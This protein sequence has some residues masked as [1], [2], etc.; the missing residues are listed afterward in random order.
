[1]ST[2][3]TMRNLLEA[4]IHFGHQTRRWHPKMARYIFGERNGI[5]IIDLKHTLRQLQK[6]YLAVRDTSAKGGT[7]LFVGTKKQAREAIQQAA[8]RSGMYYMNNR[9]L[10]GTLTNWETIQKSINKLIRLEEMETSGKAEAFSKKERVGMRKDRE[11]LEKNL[12]GIK[13][14]TTL[15]SIIFIIDAQREHIAV[16]EAKR[17]GIP[18]IAVVDTNTDPDRVPIPIPG[19]DDAIRSIQLFCSLIADAA[20]E[21]RGAFEKSKEESAAKERAAIKDAVKTSKVSRQQAKYAED[22]EEEIQ[23]TS[24]DQ[25]VTPAPSIVETPPEASDTAGATGEEGGGQVPAD[26]EPEAI[27]SSKE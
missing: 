23:E 20:I 22:G 16:Q 24:R 13:G 12:L 25:G 15:P 10:G 3:I 17:M 27:P 18:C 1:M 26:S 14:M 4:G 2:T 7:V 6:A 21:G 11:K 19:N 8:D 5:Y 9:W